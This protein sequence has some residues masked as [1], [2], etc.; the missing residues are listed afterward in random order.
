[1]EPLTGDLFPQP[2]G[3]SMATPRRRD[4][5]SLGQPARS[6]AASTPRSI[7][8][9]CLTDSALI[10]HT[11]DIKKHRP[12]NMLLAP[13]IWDKHILLR[14]PLPGSIPFASRRSP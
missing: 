14:I 8:F 2:V 4:A 11:A 12:D 1:M 7:K 13:T 6:L 5:A 9:G 10:Q 3:G